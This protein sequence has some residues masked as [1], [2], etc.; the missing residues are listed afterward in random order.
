[1]GSHHKFKDPNTLDRDGVEEKDPGQHETGEVKV[2]KKW[3]FPVAQTKLGM[4][5]GTVEESRGAKRILIFRGSST[6][7]LLWGSLD[8]QLYLVVAES[9][10][11]IV[12]ANHNGPVCPQHLQTMRDTWVGDEDCL[13]LN[14][15]NS[16]IFSK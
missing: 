8:W 4:L 5:W 15:F 11:G 1:M 6:S 7:S 9:W 3:E 16:V 13:W 2:G 12:D 14:V 10:E